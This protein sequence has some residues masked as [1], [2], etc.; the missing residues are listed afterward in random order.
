MSAGPAADRLVLQ[1]L[2]VTGR[3][4]VLAEE[5]SAGQDFVVDAVLTLD[6]RAA[7]ASDELTDTVDYA[8]LA[9]R[10]SAV[11]TGPPVALLETLAARLAE[12]CLEDPRVR[13]VEVTVHKPAAPIGLPF[14]DVSLTVHRGRE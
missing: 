4:G 12:T 8:D 10:L 9:H 6:S 5:R 14:D 7:A 1:G 2:R 13:E 11:V 3:H